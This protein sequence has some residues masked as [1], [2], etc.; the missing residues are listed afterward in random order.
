LKDAKIFLSKVN[1][2]LRKNDILWYEFLST[3]LST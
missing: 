2:Y 3:L 1:E